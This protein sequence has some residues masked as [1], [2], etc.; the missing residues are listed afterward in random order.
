M[1]TRSSDAEA[2]LT[3]HCVR[4]F[5]DSFR[6]PGPLAPSNV[7]RGLPRISLRLL[8][9]ADALL[10]GSG[11]REDGSS[12]RH[13][14]VTALPGVCQQRRE[15]LPRARARELV[16]Q[17]SFSNAGELGGLVAALP[18]PAPGPLL[19]HRIPF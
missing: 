7:H 11:P 2:A 3:Q 10:G 9:S 19:G 18:D 6:P 16:Q 15:S 12:E 14:P 8:R 5:N 1:L 17:W 13:V 4:P